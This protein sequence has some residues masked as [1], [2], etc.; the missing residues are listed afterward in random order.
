M[1]GNGEGNASMSHMI[2]AKAG[3]QIVKEGVAAGMSWTDIV[4]SCE[5]AIAVVIAASAELSGTPDRQ[6]FASDMIDTM[7]ERANNRV[8][9]LFLGV[10]YEG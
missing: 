4:I 6:R 3:S 5:T 8:V 9:A 1:P 10:P 7:T 2:G